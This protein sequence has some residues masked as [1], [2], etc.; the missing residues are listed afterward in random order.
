M[1]QV[2][3]TRRKYTK[4][5]KTKAG[6]FALL[7][8]GG[9]ALSACS[10]NLKS[11]NQNSNTS[12]S[13]TSKNPNPNNPIETMTSYLQNEG[14]KDLYGPA[15]NV[16]PGV[17]DFNCVY[18]A[19]PNDNP[20]S[21]YY[22]GPIYPGLAFS[23]LINK[24]PVVIDTAFQNNMQP[25]DN[26]FYPNNTFNDMLKQDGPSSYKPS[27][28]ATPIL[29]TEKNGVEILFLQP[30]PN[31]NQVDGAGIAPLIAFDYN[32]IFCAITPSA[33]DPYYN[34]PTDLQFYMPLVYAAEN[35]MSKG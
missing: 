15:K 20:P 31:V 25:A 10:N 1:E 34:Y 6:F 27:E 5:E 3:E 26:L 35:I 21:V 14:C 22:Q 32:N 12:T 7:A 4:Y 11:S 16:F 8:L 33:K 2:R 18:V 29:V 19:S 13:I 23:G 24:S 30:K 28:L 17:T 9:M